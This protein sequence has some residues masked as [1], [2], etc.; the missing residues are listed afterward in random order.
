MQCET[1][2]TEC[3][4]FQEIADLKLKLR[5][6]TAQCKN[7]TK[8]NYSL[9]NSNIKYRRALRKI[10]LYAPACRYE[11]DCPT[12]GGY[13]YDNGC[14]FEKCPFLVASK[15]LNEVNSKFPFDYADFGANDYSFEQTGM[16]ADYKAYSSVMNHSCFLIS[17]FSRMYCFVTSDTDSWVP[18]T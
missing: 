18:V 2:K 17:D 10:E 12:N 5:L 4:Q 15:A 7:V 8:Q 1:K 13:G 14:D 11:Q 3:E 16:L 6:T 9:Q